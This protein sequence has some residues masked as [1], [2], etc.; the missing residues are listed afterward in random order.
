MR[1]RIWVQR[2]VSADGR[3]IAQAISSVSI[4]DGVEARVYR[5]AT[6][7]A[8][9]DCNGSTSSSH[10]SVQVEWSTQIPDP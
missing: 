2:A 4:P 8:D 1:R 9:S 10:S 6:V 3:A 7:R 5:S